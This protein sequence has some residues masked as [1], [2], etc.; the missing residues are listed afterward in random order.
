MGH[1]IRKDIAK[2]V[3]DP[4][5]VSLS[6]MPNYI[7]FASI[8]DNTENKPVEITLTVENKPIDLEG[9]K[10]T[11]HQ[12]HIADCSTIRFKERKTA[13]EH[14]IKGTKEVLNI[15]N[16]TY[17]INEEDANSTLNNIKDCLLKNSFLGSNYDI[18][19]GISKNEDGTIA[20]SNTIKMTSLGA[21]ENYVIDFFKSDDDKEN[22]IVTAITHTTTS[23]ADSIDGGSGKASIELEVYTNTDSLLGENKFPEQSLGTYIATLGKAYG[24]QPLWFDLNALMANKSSFSNEFLNAEGWCNA[25]TVNDYRFIARRFDGANHEPFYLSDVLYNITGYGRSLDPT[26]LKEYVYNAQDK[27]I[28]KPLTN[29]PT[30]Y[31][32]KGQSQY[33]NFILEDENRQAD[34]QMGI[35]YRL[36]TQSKVFVAEHQTTHNGKK[37]AIVNTIKLDIDEAIADRTNIGYVEVYLNVAGISQSQPLAF[38]ILPENLYKVNDFAFLNALGGWS[39]FNFG[40]DKKNDFKA[41]TTSIF[42]T[43]TPQHT[44]SSELEAMYSKNVKEQFSVKTMSIDATTA[45]WLKEMSASVAVYEL[46]TKR[47]VVVEEMDIKQNSKDELFTVEMKYRYSDSYR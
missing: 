29:Q 24:G 42:K 18:S 45:E 8:E 5:K 16:S 22:Q 27:H 21:G 37:M 39:S 7:Q 30:L 11:E 34:H 4:K 46:S 43:Q 19:V 1:E 47:Y 35:S 25:G 38:R 23:N 36:Y 9:V 28:V 26:N 10:D 32:V 41:S 3:E 12:K 40:G 33:F 44:I 31:H 6:E 2:I 14:V 15:S 13:I 17:Y 20:M